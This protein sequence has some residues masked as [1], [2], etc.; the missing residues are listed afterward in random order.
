MYLGAN[1]YL[2]LLSVLVTCFKLGLKRGI[3]QWHKQ[4]LGRLKLLPNQLDIPL[5]IYVNPLARRL[6]FMANHHPLQ[7]SVDTVSE[8]EMIRRPIRAS[9]SCILPSWQLF[10]RWAA[11]LYR[12]MNISAAPS[13]SNVKRIATEARIISCKNLIHMVIANTLWSFLEW[14][15]F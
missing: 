2:P 6:S 8:S 12:A 10:M 13:Y 14:N 15:L 9:L 1:L 4:T 3:D 5:D 11:L 7:T